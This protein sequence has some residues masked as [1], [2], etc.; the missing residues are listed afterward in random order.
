MAGAPA[1][2]VEGGLRLARLPYVKTLEQ[3]DF[4]FQP[5]INRKLIRELARLAFVER[6]ENL[7]LLGA[8]RTGKTFL[9]VALGIKAT[10]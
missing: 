10:V 2:G 5:P 6:A 8:P 7:I 9:A 4:S 1:Q 3:F